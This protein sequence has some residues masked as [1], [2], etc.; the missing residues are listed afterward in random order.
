[1]SATVTS[2]TRAFLVA[3]PRQLFDGGFAY[4]TEDLVLRFYD[5]A[6]DGRFLMLEPADAQ[7]ASIVVAK[8]WDEELKA[9][10]PAK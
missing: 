1:M 3:P 9:R 4:D 2:T 7:G 6:A 5:M 10:V 8:N